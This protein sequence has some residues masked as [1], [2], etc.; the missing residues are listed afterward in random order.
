MTRSRQLLAALLMV[1]AL[2][3][4]GGRGPSPA[5]RQRQARQAQL[6]RDLL[7]CRR[8]QRAFPGLLQRFQQAQQRVQAADR[9]AYVPLPAP[10]PLD[11][12][13][14]SRLAIYDQESEEEAYNQALATWQQQDQWRRD[15]FAAE[16]QARLRVA[17]ADLEAAAQ[18]L[19]Q[20]HGRLLRR[21]HSPVPTDPVLD[22][23]Q[24]ERFRRCRSEDFR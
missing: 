3:G 18:P 14:Q 23:D 9:W 21:S 19:R 4:C 1:L 2:A 8:H 17:R 11:P 20:L 12:N 10:P 15:R 16:R 6:E 13:E 5:E 7:Q 24:V 22:A